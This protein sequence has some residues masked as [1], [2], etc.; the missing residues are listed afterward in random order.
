M[1][2]HLP[3]EFCVYI[4]LSV[5]VCPFGL[6]KDYSLRMKALGQI[7]L[8]KVSFQT[9]CFKSLPT[10][11]ETGLSSSSSDLIWLIF[12]HAIQTAS[13]VGRP[14]SHHTGHG[15]HIFPNASQEHCYALLCA[16]AAAERGRKQ[17]KRTLWSFMRPLGADASSP[18]AQKK[19]SPERDA[20]NGPDLAVSSRPGSLR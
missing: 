14:V 8:W 5:L 13:S 12:T 7:L 10:Q 11:S 9:C 17:R 1:C 2:G 15:A 19:S 16:R 6:R 3:E 18:L 20:E 4:T